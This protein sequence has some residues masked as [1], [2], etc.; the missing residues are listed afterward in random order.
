MG[1]IPSSRCGLLVGTP[2]D[3]KEVVMAQVVV[4]PRPVGLPPG[5]NLLL[6]GRGRTYVRHLRRRG[7]RMTVVLLHGWAA[8]ADLNWGSSYAALGERFDVVS[9]DHRGHGRGLRTTER[10]TLEH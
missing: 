1:C 3:T 8:T 7:G 9:I 5:R 4:R 2:N 10:F 6:P